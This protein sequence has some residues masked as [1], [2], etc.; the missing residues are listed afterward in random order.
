MS[1]A[2]SELTIRDCRPDDIPPV[3]GLWRQAG[4][5]P[6]VTDTADDLRR[7]I[8]ESP[9]HVLVADTG[10]HVIGSIIG[11][12]DGWRANIYRLAVHPDHRRRGVARALV[13][14]IE[15]RLAR[16]GARRITA[17]VEKEHPWAMSFWQAAGYP[18]DEQIVRRVRTLHV[19]GPAPF[20][21]PAMT[22]AVN[23]DIHLSEL[24]PCDKAA[25]VEHLNNKAIYDRL[26]AVP[27]PYTQ[28]DAEEWIALSAKAARQQ[29]QPIH[30]AVRDRQACLIGGCGFDGLQLGKSHRAEIAYWLAKPYWGRGIMPAVVQRVCDFAFREWGLS[31]I[32]AHI[33]AFNHASARVL[34]KCGFAQE[35]YLKKHYLK[36]GTFIDARLYSLLR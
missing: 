1:E 13:A 14:E 3:L 34:E 10:G 23:E 17:L 7:A 5:T 22:L 15:K 8:A 35:A 6:G 4:A 31:K 32:T 20:E 25:M 26:L 19:D 11:T 30:W 2:A 9:A 18:V 29:G 28:A 27:Y 21:C 12:F 36:D 33:F 16:L 24:R